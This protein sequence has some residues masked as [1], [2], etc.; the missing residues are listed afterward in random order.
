MKKPGVASFFSYNPGRSGL[1]GAAVGAYRGGVVNRCENVLI[2]CPELFPKTG[3]AF[4]PPQKTNTTGDIWNLR[5]DRELPRVRPDFIQAHA[6]ASTRSMRRCAPARSSNS[7]GPFSGK[8]PRSLCVPQA[9]CGD[10]RQ[11]QFLAHPNGTRTACW[12]FTAPRTATGVALQGH[13][14]GYRDGRRRPA[15]IPRRFT[16]RPADLGKIFL[17]R[18]PCTAAEMGPRTPFPAVNGGVTIN[19]IRRKSR[20]GKVAR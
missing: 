14:P 17:A 3:G 20:H 7:A 5:S 9:L 12:R 15:R 1:S 11:T 2:L 4:L 10:I 16:K 6:M 8:A 18:M 13:R 19:W